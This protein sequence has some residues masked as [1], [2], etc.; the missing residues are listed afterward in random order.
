MSGMRSSVGQGPNPEWYEQF[1]LVA[2]D[3]TLTLAVHQKGLLGLLAG[4]RICV[5]YLPAHPVG[6]Q[7]SVLAG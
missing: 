6:C 2:R 3:V 4:P 1:D 5:F 7:R